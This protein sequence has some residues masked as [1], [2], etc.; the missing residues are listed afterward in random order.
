MELGACANLQSF[1]DRLCHS[2]SSQC[3]VPYQSDVSGM[4]KCWTRT[5]LE[6]QGAA[7]CQPFAVHHLAAFQQQM[8]VDLLPFGRLFASCHAIAQELAAC[9]VTQIYP[10]A[11]FVRLSRG[12]VCCTLSVQDCFYMLPIQIVYNACWVM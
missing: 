6:A 5:A 12:D 10:H 1:A 11:H 4:Y 9:T 3:V 8:Q 7:C 2:E